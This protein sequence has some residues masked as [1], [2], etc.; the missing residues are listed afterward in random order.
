MFNFW[1]VMYLIIVG[2]IAGHVAR[3]LIKSANPM[4]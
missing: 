3:L 4:T 1:T 2:L